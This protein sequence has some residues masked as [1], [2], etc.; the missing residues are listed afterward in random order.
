MEE[1]AFV[2]DP[3]LYKAGGGGNK[4]CNVCPKGRLS[5]CVA[6]KFI[7]VDIYHSFLICCAEMK[8]TAFANILY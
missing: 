8:K 1:F 6:Q 3:D 7:P 2:P 4:I 5:S